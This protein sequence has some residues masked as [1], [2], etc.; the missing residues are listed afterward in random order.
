MAP[1]CNTKIRSSGVTP[2]CAGRTT[3]W[4]AELGKD[5]QPAKSGPGETAFGTELAEPNLD[6]EGVPPSMF[7]AG[8]PVDRTDVLD[9]LNWQYRR[10]AWADVRSTLRS[11][12]LPRRVTG[13]GNRGRGRGIQGASTTS[14]QRVSGQDTEVGGIARRA[15]RRSRRRRELRPS[16]VVG[17]PRRQRGGGMASSWAADR[18]AL[19]SRAART[20]SISARPPRKFMAQVHGAVSPGRVAGC[21]D[22]RCWGGL[23]EDR[24]RWWSAVGRVGGKHR[25]GVES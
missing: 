6:L 2:G 20:T 4:R 17:G 18:R 13:G 7:D 23:S 11:S 16:R 22:D 10:A 3:R 9:G 1:A 21:W 12:T 25:V 15:Q 19:R 5:A 14:S 8:G 24:C